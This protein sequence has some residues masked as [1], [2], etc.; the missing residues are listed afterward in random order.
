VADG[1]DGLFF[2]LFGCFT[3]PYFALKSI[4]MFSK[5]VTMAVWEG[6]KTQFTNTYSETA[7]MNT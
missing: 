5:G 3:P 1:Y 7:S 6:C 4:A 2:V